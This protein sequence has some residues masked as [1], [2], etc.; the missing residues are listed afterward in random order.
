MITKFKIFESETYSYERNI[1][2]KFLDQKIEKELKEYLYDDI[3]IEIN[4]F[5]DSTYEDLYDVF[6]KYEDLRPW[7][8]IP[9]QQKAKEFLNYKNYY[10]SNPEFLNSLNKIVDE[11]VEELNIDDAYDKTIIKYFKNHHSDWEMLNDLYDF[12]DNVKQQLSY[13]S[14]ARKFKI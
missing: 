12:T 8:N 11:V 13:I 3:V 1:D 5:K 7:G 10:A 6:F 4:K 9:L 14:K 2:Y